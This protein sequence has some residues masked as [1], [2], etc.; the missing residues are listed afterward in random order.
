MG[1][2]GLASVAI[3]VLRPQ[4]ALKPASCAL[5]Y[6]LHGTQSERASIAIMLSLFFRVLLLVLISGAARGSAQ[7]LVLGVLEDV[8]GA[9]AGEPSSHGVRVL[10]QKNATDWEAFPNNC[11]DQ[12]CLKTISS[13]YPRELTWTIVFDGR[14]LGQVTGRTPKEFE[15]YSHVGLQVVVS[16][17]AIPTVGKRSAEYGGSTDA[18]VYRPLVAV[19]RPYF[20]DPESWKPSNLPADMIRLFRQEFRKRFPTVSNCTSPADAAE[21]P[22]LYN[23]EN[24]R[25]LKRYSSNRHW[26]VVQVR[27]GE[28]RCNGPPDD[29]FFDYWFALSPTNDI[30]LLG[31]GLWL[32]D[33]G[34]YDNDGKSE[35]VFAIDRY[36]QGGYELFYADFKKHATFEFGYH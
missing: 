13:K 18:S 20:K 35:L 9:Y 30:T 36:N 26:S 28:Y 22:W 34:D 3:E 8:P 2:F 5:A 27:L 17:G 19:S 23:D 24:I 31:N 15:L 29:P 25:I 14:D 33:A 6:C 32:V 1:R 21:K 4:S 11:P 12:G 16:N 7:N 10:F